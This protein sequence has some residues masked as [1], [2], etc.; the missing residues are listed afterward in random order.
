MFVGSQV[1]VTVICPIENLPFII[2]TTMTGWILFYATHPLIYKNTLVESF[3]NTEFETDEEAAILVA[4][5]CEPQQKLFIAD[6]NN[7]I[8]CY[9]I[10]NFLK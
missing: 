9:D 7:Y 4:A 6:E 10:S 1:E 5:F 3:V 8:K 2:A